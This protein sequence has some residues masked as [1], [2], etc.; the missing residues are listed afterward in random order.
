MTL[1]LALK[2]ASATSA[3]NQRS[4][5]CRRLLAL[6]CLGLLSVGCTSIGPDFE[7]PEVPGMEDWTDDNPVITRDSIDL[8][9]W[10]TVFND[11]ILN[12][13]IEESFAQNLSL[14]LTG[15]RI[16]EARA[17]LGVAEG[18]RYPQVQ[19]I[20]GTV[21]TSQTSENGPLSNPATNDE[22]KSYEFGFDAVWEIDF[23]GRIGRGI[24]AADA[25]L[26]AS[27]ADY[28]DALVSLA[29]EVARVYITIRTLETRL[30]LARENILLQ[31][32]SLRIATVR[33][34]NGATT[35]L[36][37]Q[38]AKSNLASTQASIPALTS[39]LYQAMNGLAVLLGK[40]PGK[41]QLFSSINN[42]IPVAPAFIASGIPSELLRRRPD[43]RS[44]E[45]QAASQSALIGVA[46][47]DLYPRF[48]L[49]GTIGTQSSN[50]GN[51]DAG[52][53]FSSDSVF[54]SAG[55]TFSWNIF[56]YGQIRNRVR[57]QD[58][59]YQQT[60]VNYQ[61]TVLRAYQE[62][63]DAMV[64]FL[65]AQSEAGFRQQS[66]T[67][68]QRA[69]EIANIQYREGASEFQRVIDTERTLVAQQDAWTNARGRI[70]LNLVALYKAL[71]GGWS[72]PDENSSDQDYVSAETRKDMT[73]RTN[74]GDLLESP[75]VEN[76]PDETQQEAAP[77]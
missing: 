52:D 25:S 54:F 67:A 21:A 66:A 43:I 18:N 33:F 51:S 20:G 45:F 61:N 58:A 41:L 22:F 50:I 3:T 55:P 4:H 59:R 53:L 68:A 13:L 16:L 30:T 70:A 57:E 77:Q 75:P 15:L 42:D 49:F 29:A 44:A 40:P 31:T 69:S 2:R 48:A 63:E 37:V 73:E 56:N 17:R 39:S 27:Y 14:Q 34:D 19:E 76:K 8:R 47:G 71:G 7:K 26:N 9:N 28:D 1:P 32:E 23:W 60:L 12:G 64:G 5:I 74:W 46:E 11:P 10:W 72:P 35:N 36:D 38:Q 62:T 65:Q 6:L 24:E